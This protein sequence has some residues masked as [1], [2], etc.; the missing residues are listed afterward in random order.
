MPRSAVALA[1][2]I[3][4]AFLVALPRVL[5]A[6]A[7]SE[8]IIDCARWGSG[9]YLC[10]A[11]D[12]CNR[13][14]K[15]PRWRMDIAHRAV[16]KYLKCDL[17][18]RTTGTPEKVEQCRWRASKLAAGMNK[19]QVKFYDRR[20][21]AFRKG[22]FDLY[23]G[24][25]DFNP[26]FLGTP[27]GLGYATDL[28][29]CA[30][31]GL[32][33]D[34]VFDYHECGDTYTTRLHARILG[35]AEPR[36]R[37]FLEDA[38]VEGTTGPGDMGW[39]ALFPEERV[40]PVVCN[41]GFPPR[42]AISP[43]ATPIAGTSE[44]RWC[45]NEFFKQVQTAEGKHLDLL[46]QCSEDYLMCNV[47]SE[48]GDITQSAYDQCLQDAYNHCVDL[49]ETTDSLNAL[50]I[51]SIKEACNEIAWQDVTDI[52]GFGDIAADCGATDVD[53]LVDCIADQVKC[54]AWDVARFVEGRL[55]YDT[56][57]EFIADYV[58]LCEN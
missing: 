25:L 19:R 49:R 29:T 37:E 14:H 38:P 28:P 50:H 41:V 1:L 47:K 16:S 22:Q 55:L 27:L 32:P 43:Q 45:Q 52:L 35:L 6:A 42:P 40:S 26:E 17:W 11:I 5:H 53:D 9:L 33:I 36:T 20:H 54:L 4:S 46:E 58:S 7:R 30:A 13:N 34:E 18:G 31:L 56:P 51:G 2:A 57:P 48:N 44:I 10:D 3:S 24:A 15:L 8:A 39:C 23:C 21:T 12:S